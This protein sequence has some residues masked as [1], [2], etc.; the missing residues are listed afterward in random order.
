M[1]ALQS[2]LRGGRA[3][4]KTAAGAGKRRATGGIAIR[5]SR[6]WRPHGVARTVSRAQPAHCPMPDVANELAALLMPPETPA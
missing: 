6:G 3:G 4:D 5:A 2:P 1:R